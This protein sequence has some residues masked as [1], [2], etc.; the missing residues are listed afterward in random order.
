MRSFSF[1]ELQQFAYVASHDLQEPLRMVSSY[2]SMLEKN[3]KDQ[4]Y[5]KANLFISFAVDGSRRMSNLI[6][7]LLAY[8]RVTSQ[9]RDFEIVDLNKVYN[10][11]THDL[12]ILIKE[13]GAKINSASLP[14]I[15]ADPTQMHQ[16]LQ[17]LR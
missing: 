11:V 15:K 3:Y 8:S 6:W 16:L 7:D 17:N 1:K 4:L 12:K 5:D 14:V 2:M 10:N 9:A 13:K